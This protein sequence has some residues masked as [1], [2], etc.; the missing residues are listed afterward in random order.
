M[1]VRDIT[2]KSQKLFVCK[3]S[4]VDSS[5]ETLVLPEII[6]SKGP[7]P[8]N[9]EEVLTEEV[10]KPKRTLANKMKALIL[11]KHSND[12]IMRSLNS[13]HRMQASSIQGSQADLRK[14]P[15]EISTTQLGSLRPRL[16]LQKSG[17]L[18]SNDGET[19]KVAVVDHM[20][21]EP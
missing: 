21:P 18:A 19:L 6:R 1:I 15:I 7:S 9:V 2:N 3:G 20:T 16:I 12:M 4:S 13:K 5:S 17:T 8:V 14:S 10:K 11:M